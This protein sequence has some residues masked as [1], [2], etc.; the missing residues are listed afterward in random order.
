MLQM[1]EAAHMVGAK[2]AADATFL[3]PR[4]QHEMIDYQLAPPVEQFGYRLPAGE[5]LEDIFLVD[6]DPGQRA[7]FGA[8]PVALARE[9][10][11]LREERR[12][13]GK[14][15]IARNDRVLLQAVLLDFPYRPEW[16]RSHRRHRPL[17]IS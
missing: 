1:H 16:W 9:F 12:A 11:F 8:Q 6:L 15:F 3:P 10:L 7:P 14:P 13:C 4:P 17:K 5:C 2:R